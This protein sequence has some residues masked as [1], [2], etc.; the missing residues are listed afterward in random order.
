MAFVRL[1]TSKVD[2]HRGSTRAHDLEAC[3][4]APSSTADYLIDDLSRER[5]R[6]RMA[7]ATAIRLGVQR[8]RK[9]EN[10]RHALPCS[11]RVVDTIALVGADPQP[12]P[13]TIEP[14]ARLFSANRWRGERSRCPPDGGCGGLL[15]DVAA[16]TS[17]G[18]SRAN[19]GNAPLGRSP[20]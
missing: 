17:S 8:R 18:I 12:P 1:R 9:L 10:R 2:A 7:T 14:T 19:L 20:I 11:Q 3:H 4:Q 15:G 13:E 6:A 16:V 5:T